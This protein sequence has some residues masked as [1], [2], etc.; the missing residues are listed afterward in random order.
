MERLRVMEQAGRPL[1]WILEATWELVE[2]SREELWDVIAMWDDFS[3]R[4]GDLVA[5]A[6]D[7]RY[8]MSAKSQANLRRIRALRRDGVF[9]L[10]ELVAV[11]P[12]LLKLSYPESAM[13]LLDG[14][15]RILALALD[16]ALPDVFPV[17][18]GNLPVHIGTAV[19]N[20]LH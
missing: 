4:L 11:R 1:F 14:H 18:L 8:S 19:L 20:S 16:E 13:C 3:M 15:H 5:R 12:S 17:L 10:G 6:L 2:L 9:R 7:G